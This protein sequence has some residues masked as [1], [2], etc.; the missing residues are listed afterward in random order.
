MD[1]V[2]GEASSADV[3]FGERRLAL[4]AVL[5][6]PGGA[7]GAGEAALPLLSLIAADTRFEAA[8]VAA[9]VT[10]A[11]AVDAAE[12]VDAAAAAAAFVAA[13]GPVGIDADAP[14]PLFFTVGTLGV[15]AFLD[16]ER[17]GMS[18][19]LN[20]AGSPVII[21]VGVEGVPAGLPEAQL[22]VLGRADGSSAAGDAMDVDER[23]AR[24]DEGAG[25]GEATEAAAAAADTLLAAPLF[26]RS[27]AAWRNVLRSS[28]V[29]LS[30]SSPGS[31]RY[32]HAGLVQGRLRRYVVQYL[33]VP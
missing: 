31:W 12:A 23:A 33:V 25:E 22:A 11:A 16:A 28:F 17:G 32:V 1:G 24:A 2:G 18:E 10:V 21:A 29:K 13:L 5:V 9:D 20:A 19:S 15:L 14:P 30:A 4:L 27:R 8:D 3:G 26:S 6:R 7:G